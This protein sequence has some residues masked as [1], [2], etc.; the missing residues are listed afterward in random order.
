MG[1]VG[2]VGGVGGGG[3]GDG[4][5]DDAG[6]RYMHMIV[7]AHRG[8]RHRFP[9]KLELICVCEPSHRGTGK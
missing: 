2:G 1:G 5:D 4:G 6:G 3:D 9:L 7:A 8:Q